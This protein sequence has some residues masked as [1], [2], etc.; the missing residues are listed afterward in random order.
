MSSTK[1]PEVT[2]GSFGLSNE[3]CGNKRNCTYGE[4]GVTTCR[5]LCAIC[6]QLQ[7]M[8]VLMEELIKQNQSK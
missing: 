3:N 7:K 4:Y 8:T 2:F 5:H 6:A 1:N